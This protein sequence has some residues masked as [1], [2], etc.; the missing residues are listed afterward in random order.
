[1]RKWLALGAAT[2]MA[3]VSGAWAVPA[4]ADAGCFDRA[5]QPY[6][7]VVDSHFHLRPFGGAGIPLT[8]MGE[9]W[10]QTGVRYVNLY[11]IGQIRR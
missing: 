6:T 8:E 11:G 9:Y 1:M 7:S 2:V 4:F 10:R 3:V 5:T